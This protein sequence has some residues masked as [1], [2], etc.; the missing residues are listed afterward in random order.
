MAVTSPPRPGGQAAHRSR[1]VLVVVL[2]LAV[3]GV[4]LA[5]AVTGALLLVHKVESI[6]PVRG[7]GIAATQT[8]VVP[9]FSRVD[10]MGSN[11]VTVM[12]GGKQ[13]VVIHAD[14]N[15]IDRVTTRVLA[16]T[17]VIGNK[18]SFTTKSPMSVEVRVPS[19]AAM[20]LN[21]TGTISASGINASRLV[22]TLSGVGTFNAS[23]TATHLVVA[24]NGLGQARLS[25]LAARDVHA[26]INGSGQIRVTAS[27]SLQAVINGSGTIIYSGNPPQVSTTV[28]GNGTVTRG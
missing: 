6:S 8:R 16:G 23:G 5:L 28:A 17:L 19:L 10:L 2:V 11:N 13:S 25:H 21:G 24:V 1:P 3:V 7:S 27:K 18:G 20:T 4:L 9:R 14:N 22:M 15:L 26:V 12:V